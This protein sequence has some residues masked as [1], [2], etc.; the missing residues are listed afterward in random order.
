LRP[1]LRTRESHV[2]GWHRELGEL[3]QYLATP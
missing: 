1:E 2:E 3:V